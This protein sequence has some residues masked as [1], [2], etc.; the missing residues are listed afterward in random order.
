[1][2][3]N[4]Q[5]FKYASQAFSIYNGIIYLKKN[6]ELIKDS[7]SEKY[8]L[9]P[10]SER[11][12]NAIASSTEEHDETENLAYDTHALE[13]LMYK[14]FVISVFIF[15]E[16]RVVD[17][18]KYVKKTKNQV[19]S[20]TDIKG[21]RGIGQ[22]LKYLQTL[23]ITFC[24]EGIKKDLDAGLKIRNAIVHNDGILENGKK[25]DIT[26]E[27]ALSLIALSSSV[28]DGVLEQFK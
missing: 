18:C 26:Y 16:A 14:S 5:S 11:V 1:M 20:H 7:I 24:S 6:L 15:I 2:V 22:S 3:E 25:I 4:N 23:D 9:D 21:P 8:S 13:Q 27:Y 19:F 17:L 12:L 28:C 10:A